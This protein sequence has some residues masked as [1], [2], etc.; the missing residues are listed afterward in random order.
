VEGLGANHDE[1]IQKE[2]NGFD[3]EGTSLA[4]ANR[5]EKTGKST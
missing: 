5:E 2:A 1:D 4:T 3:V